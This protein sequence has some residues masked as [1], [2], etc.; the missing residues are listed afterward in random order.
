MPIVERTSTELLFSNIHGMLN[1]ACMID[2]YK[3]NEDNTR[4][5]RPE[6]S[7]S[8]FAKAQKQGTDT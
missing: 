4:T 3:D 7:R 6:E 8:T 5:P 1:D 2:I